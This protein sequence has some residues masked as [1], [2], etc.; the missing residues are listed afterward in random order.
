M[1]LWRYAV[2]TRLVRPDADDEEIQLLTQ[3]LTPSLAGY[4]TLIVAALFAPLVAAVGYLA[5]A[6][7]LIILFRVRDIVRFRRRRR[8]QR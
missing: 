3:R 4:L 8:A 7:F 2:H 6:L 5:V 1:V